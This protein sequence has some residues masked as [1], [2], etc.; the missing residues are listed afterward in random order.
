MAQAWIAVF[1]D[2]IVGADQNEVAYQ[3][4]IQNLYSFKFKPA[5][6]VTQLLGLTKKWSKLVLKSCTA[7]ATCLARIL[8]ASPSGANTEYYTWLGTALYNKQD[9]NR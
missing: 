5:A 6:K 2:G 3:S 9:F 7:L 8:H 4:T 1:N